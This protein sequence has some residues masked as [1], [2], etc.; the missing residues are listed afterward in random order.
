MDRLFVNF[1]LSGFP[2]PDSKKTDMG[3]QKLAVR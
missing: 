2:A 3:E 1:L